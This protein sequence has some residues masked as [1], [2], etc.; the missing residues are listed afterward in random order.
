MEPKIIRWSL[1][2]VQIERVEWVKFDKL[3]KGLIKEGNLVRQSK[4]ESRTQ[5]S[6]KEKWGTS[7][8]NKNQ[9]NLFLDN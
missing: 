6:I 7:S 4:A 9:K 8:K 5:R 3:K 1:E 2:T